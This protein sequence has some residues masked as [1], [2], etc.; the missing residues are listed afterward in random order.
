LRQFVLSLI[1]KQGA[2]MWDYS[3]KVQEHFFSPRNAGA[4]SDANA[5]S[6]DFT[7]ASLPSADLRSF[8]ADGLTLTV[9]AARFHGGPSPSEIILGKRT[10][11]LMTDGLGV[12]DPFDNTAIDGKWGNDILILSFSEQVTIDAIHFNRVDGNDEFAF[13]HVD[14]LT[15][16]RVVDFEP[17][18]STVNA[19]TFAT[20]IERTGQTMGIGAIGRNDNFTL[21]G[22]EVSLEERAAPAAAT[23][24]N[25]IPLPPTILMLGAALLG[26]G[27]AR[28]RSNRPV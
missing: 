21:A 14:G 19:A 18:R 10:V 15:F 24:A 27:L 6:F 8:T 17:A 20:F 3:E 9:T 22:L 23:A 25:T 13:G 11:D 1:K 2:V 26:L 5:V 12:G 4:V 16:S 28:R 7:G